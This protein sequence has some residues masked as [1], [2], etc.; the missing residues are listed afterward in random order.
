MPQNFK[1]S[2][3][4]RTPDERFANLPGFPFTP[5]YL[6]ALPSFSG[7]RMHYLNENPEGRYTFLCLH[8]E[9]TWSYL[10]RR[11]IPIFTEAGHQVVAPDF[12]GFGRSDK[13]EEDSLYTFDFHRQ[14]LIEF[15]TA[16]DLKNIVMVCQDWGGVLGLTLPMDMPERFVGLF[17]MDTLIGNGEGIPQSFFDWR[18]YMR[19]TPDL[20]CA[21]LLKRACAHLTDEEAVAY[22]APF[23][24]ARYK[25]GV[26]RFPELVPDNP[27]AQGA[28]ISRR[29]EKWLN[30]NWSG[31]AVAVAGMQDPV[32]PPDMLRAIAANIKNC[33]PPLEVAEAGHFVQEW[34]VD[35]T[36]RALDILDLP[37]FR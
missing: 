8:G 33:P 25:A 26:R 19:S 24:D 32:L 34:G 22:N 30:E 14:S 35:F 4:L 1:G 2:E 18:N 27:N 20:D 3:V 36:R 21:K 28:D 23:P 5:F 10:Y 11:M 17:V 13:P 12:F 29:A 15:I 9:P 7:L 16:L 6:D 37:D 31:K